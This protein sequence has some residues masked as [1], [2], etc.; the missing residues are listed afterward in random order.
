MINEIVFYPLHQLS[1]LIKNKTIS[2][3]ELI[4]IFHDHI[5]T[6][7]KKNQL[8]YRPEICRRIIG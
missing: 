6:Y 5:S 8:H 4:T 3:K 7:E 1:A 2:S